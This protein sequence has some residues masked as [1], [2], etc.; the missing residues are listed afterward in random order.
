MYIS[1]KDALQYASRLILIFVPLFS[2]LFDTWSWIVEILLLFAVF[3]HNRGSGLRLTGLLLLGAYLAAFIPAGGNILQIGFSPWAAILFLTLKEK[4]LT[5]SQSMLWGLL[6]AAILG[7]LPVI[8]VVK[9]VTQPEYIQEKVQAALDFYKQQ[10]T[11]TALEKQGMSTVEFEG[12]LNKVMPTYYKLMPGIA[13]I[14]GMLELGFAYF[15][16][17]VSLK[18]E[19][20]VPP[21]SLWHFPWYAVWGIIVGI[22]IYLGGGYLGIASLEIIGLNIMLMMAVL[23]LLIGLSCLSFYIKHPKRPKVMI[24]MLIFIGVFFP[25]YVLMGL[26]LI[27]FFDMVINFRRIPEKIVGGKQ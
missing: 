8:P 7:A 4:G 9:M 22:A 19:Q 5:T 3:I 26:I 21:F 1:D 23:S 6:L 20:P 2:S 17:R 16:Y 27:G 25:S 13:G 18:K 11:L 15:I 10:G 24:L 14:M 12:Y